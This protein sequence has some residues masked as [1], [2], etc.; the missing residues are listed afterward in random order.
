MR[1]FLVGLLLTFVA[2]SAAAGQRSWMSNSEL[3]TAFAG[4]TI[5]GVYRDGR[6]FKEAYHAG[7]RL[8][9]DEGSRHITGHWSVINGTFCTIYDSEASGG[10]FRVH[11]I[12][13]NCYEFYFQS[14]DEAEAADPKR[15][16]RPSWTAQAWRTNALSTCA[17]RP[18]V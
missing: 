17:Q 11:R 14:R 7:G 10:C 8:N 12:S 18:T 5:E 1:A 3:R 4:K 6:A 13:A 15:D 9:Y 16:R 2:V